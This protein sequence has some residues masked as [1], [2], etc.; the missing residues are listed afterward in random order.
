MIATGILL[1]SSE[2]L[3]LC[4]GFDFALDQYGTFGY[5]CSHGANGSEDWCQH[6]ADD[7][8]SQRQFDEL[9]A[10]LAELMAAVVIL[11]LA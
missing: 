2:P 8:N 1:L 7:S 3:F 5:K 9:L 10:S 6:S 4:F 11:M